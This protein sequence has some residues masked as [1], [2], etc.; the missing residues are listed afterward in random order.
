M[1]TKGTERWP[2]PPPTPP[3]PPSPFSSRDH[4]ESD[5]TREE[6]RVAKRGEELATYKREIANCEV[7]RSRIMSSRRP[8]I[9]QTAAREI[10]ERMWEVLEYYEGLM[11]DAKE[12]RNLALQAEWEANLLQ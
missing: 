11:M 4:I 6:K 10:E 9:P 5:R 3:T 7:S 2:H 1:E 12:K 8:L